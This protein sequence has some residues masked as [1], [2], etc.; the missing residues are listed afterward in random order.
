MPVML[1][2]VVCDEADAASLPAEESP[3]VKVVSQQN[4]DGSWSPSGN[5]EVLLGLKPQEIGQR[6]PRQDMD[7][8][9]WVTIL[10]VIWL[11]AFCADSKDE[12]E[13]LVDKSLSWIKANSGAD[14]GGCVKAGNDLLKTSVNPHV[15][16]L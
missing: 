10:T 13:L 2:S 14:L 12:W 16:D 3:L 4:A 15:F 11:H 8:T 7:L 6:V 1:D 5:L 9:L